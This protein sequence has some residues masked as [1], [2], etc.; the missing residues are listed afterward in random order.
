MSVEQTGKNQLLHTVE[1]V[2]DREGQYVP[3]RPGAA[4]RVL[5]CPNGWNEVTYDRADGQS[6]SGSKDVASML[7]AELIYLAAHELELGENRYVKSVHHQLVPERIVGAVDWGL[8]LGEM[9]L[10]QLKEAGYKLEAP[11]TFVAHEVQSGMA[12]RFQNGVLVVRAEQLKSLHNLKQAVG[13]TETASNSA[14]VRH[15]LEKLAGAYSPQEGYAW[16]VLSG[17]HETKPGLEVVLLAF[18]KMNA[19]HEEQE[20]AINTQ[21]AA[22]LAVYSRAAHVEALRQGLPQ[23]TRQ[24]VGQVRDVL[25]SEAAGGKGKGVSTLAEIAQLAGIVVRPT[26]LVEAVALGYH[27]LWNSALTTSESIKGRFIA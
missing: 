27:A 25:F 3:V 16:K 21:R 13:S 23:P 26:D 10:W 14:V 12:F 2:V 24:L 6:P 20:Q 17:K 4:T 18:G 7:V 22:Q 9:A 5:N 15:L 19:S 1:G 8:S 11:D